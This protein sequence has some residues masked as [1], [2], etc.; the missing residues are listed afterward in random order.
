LRWRGAYRGGQRIFLLY[1]H[2]S[3]ATSGVQQTCNI[4]IFSDRCRGKSPLS[5]VKEVY[6]LAVLLLLL[7]LFLLLLGRGGSEWRGPHFGLGRVD[8]AKQE[9]R[10]KERKLKV[11][12]RKGSTTC[13]NAPKSKAQSSALHPSQKY[14]T[15]VVRLNSC[16]PVLTGKTTHTLARCGAGPQDQ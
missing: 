10:R 16:V 5:G 7:L 11:K 2:T 13:M 12:Q 3:T 1:K 15:R 6:M 9:Q 4:L 14:S 8:P